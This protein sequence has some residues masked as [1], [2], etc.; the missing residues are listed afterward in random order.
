MKKVKTVFKGDCWSSDDNFEVKYVITIS[1]KEAVRLI[2][3]MDIMKELKEKHSDKSLRLL[4]AWADNVE[5]FTG[6]GEVDC[7]VCKVQVDSY[8]ILYELK[9]KYNTDIYET[10]EILRSELEEIVKM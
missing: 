8:G 7:D 9:N 10:G 4:S 1:K 3:L 5:V 6:D 2:E